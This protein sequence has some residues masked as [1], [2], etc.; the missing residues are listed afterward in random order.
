MKYI[1]SYKMDGKWYEMES[2]KTEK[3]ALDYLFD[4]ISCDAKVYTN[5]NHEDGKAGNILVADD[6]N[7]IYS[8]DAVKGV[9]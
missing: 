1:V 3:K 2:F 4:E 8:V 7:N 9:A 5:Y 6:W